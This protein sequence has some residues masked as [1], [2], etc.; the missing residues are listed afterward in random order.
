MGP[1]SETNSNYLLFRVQNAIELFY[2]L[3]LKSS[4]LPILSLINLSVVN[5]IIK[6]L[7]LRNS[8]FLNNGF[9]T[10]MFYKY[11]KQYLNIQKEVKPKEISVP[12]LPVFLSIPYHGY[13]SDKKLN[14]S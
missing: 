1:G 9:P 2:L 14:Q 12:K 8:F 6:Y 7:T 3:F 5:W 11:V 10:T 4:S 13:F